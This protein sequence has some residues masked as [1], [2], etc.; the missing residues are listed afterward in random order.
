V[1]LLVTLLVIVAVV[2]GV[3]GFTMAAYGWFQMASIVDEVTK[4]E[5]AKPGGGGF[6]AAFEGRDRGGRIREKILKGAK[7]ASVDLRPEQLSINVVDGMLDVRLAWDA[8]MIRYQGTSYLD[9][10]MTLQRGFPLKSQ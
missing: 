6:S 2:Y 3:Y 10:P 9:I 8:P 5:L 4:E 7:E 1:K